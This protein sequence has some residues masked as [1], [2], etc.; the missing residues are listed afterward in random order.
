MSLKLLLRAAGV[1][2][3]PLMWSAAAQAQDVNLT[4]KRLEFDDRARG[5]NEVIVFNRGDAAATFRVE[6][7]DRLMQTDG[8]MIEGPSSAVGSA[9]SFVRF[10]PRRVTLGPGE[11]QVIRVQ[12]RA[13]GDL[14]T[15]EYRTH[16]TVSALP[17]AGSEADATASGSDDAAGLQIRLVP[18]FGMSIPVIVRQGA[19]EV[20]VGI[21]NIRA[22]QADGRPAVTFDLTR[23]G[24]RS[25][26]G[27]LTV[28]LIGATGEQVV[29]LAR[30]VGVYPE[31]PYRTVVLPLMADA[32][33]LPSGGRVRVT[34]RDAAQPDRTLASGEV[35]LP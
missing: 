3:L 14:P 27:D 1:F 33:L 18:V 8:S 32:P 31:I 25:A 5:A 28:E 34:Y 15:G 30:G 17:V 16:L 7:V 2:L 24:S 23:S 19:P 21:E 35:L 20:S 12:A 22:T 11:S 10:S 9:A 4:P 6:L 13:P 29:A 26:Y